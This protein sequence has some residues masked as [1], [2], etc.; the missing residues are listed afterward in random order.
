MGFSDYFANASNFF[1]KNANQTTRTVADVN[2][3]VGAR[4]AALK[5][6]RGFGSAVNTALGVISEPRKQYNYRVN[7][8]FGAVLGGIGGIEA[9]IKSCTRP[10]IN[11][12]Y[13]ETHVFNSVKRSIVGVNFEPITMEIYDDMAGTVTN[14]IVSML[15]NSYLLNVDNTLSDGSPIDLGS[16]QNAKIDSI[17]IHSGSSP[18]SSLVGGGLINVAKNGLQAYKDGPIDSVML[19]D[20]NIIG[21]DFG[22][23]DY[24]N[25]SDPCMITLKFK[26]QSLSFGNTTLSRDIRSTAIQKAIGSI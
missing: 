2:D 6:T 17:V 12:D 4:Q 20:C 19:K 22:N 9:N 13:K 15:R 23:F 8:N 24:A 21:V 5:T 3:A 16:Y 7:I 26:Y 11:F 25:E 1:K 14:D 18:V 10:S